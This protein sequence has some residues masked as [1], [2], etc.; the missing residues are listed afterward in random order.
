MNKTYYIYIISDSVGET[1]EHIARA[2]AEQFRD[3]S[4]EIKKIFVYRR[5]Q[6]SS[7]NN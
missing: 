7:R 2:T 6:S 4:Y 3:R 1:A 5:Q